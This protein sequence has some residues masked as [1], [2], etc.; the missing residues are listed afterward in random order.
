MQTRLPL[1]AQL[2]VVALAVGT[3]EVGTGLAGLAAPI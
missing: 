3:T 2:A 1:L